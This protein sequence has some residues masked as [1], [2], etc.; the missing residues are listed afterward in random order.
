[1]KAKFKVSR[2]LKVSGLGL[3]VHGKL[4][5]GN[6][7]VGDKGHAFEREFLILSM[8]KGDERKSSAVSGEELSLWL[9][10]I[11]PDDVSHGSTLFF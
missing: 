4:V 10:G 7:N 6:L 8:G 2:V 9:K 3:V 5:E 1:M 11:T